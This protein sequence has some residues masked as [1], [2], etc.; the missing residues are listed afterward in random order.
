M[1]NSDRKQKIASFSIEKYVLK[2]FNTYC[3]KNHLN[4]SSLIENYIKNFIN[5]KG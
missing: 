1:K 3:K 2:N 4:K 5:E